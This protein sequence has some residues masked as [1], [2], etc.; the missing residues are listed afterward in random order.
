ME[1][2][3]YVM[4]EIYV[5]LD[6]LREEIEEAIQ[7]YLVDDLFRLRDFLLRLRDDLKEIEEEIDKM[8]EEIE[9]GIDG[10]GYLD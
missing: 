4:N 6:E 9:E 2:V 5:N 3:K 1:D 7:N 8:I 10:I